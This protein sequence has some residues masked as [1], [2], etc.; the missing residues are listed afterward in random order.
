MDP[1]HDLWRRHPRAVASTLGVKTGFRSAEAD[2]YHALAADQSRI[3]TVD[4]RTEALVIGCIWRTMFRSAMPTFVV[5]NTP[6]Q[7]KWLFEVAEKMIG[8][9]GDVRGL[10]WV[11]YGHQ[12][13]SLAS[14]SSLAVV[15]M[16]PNELTEK[17][18]PK[19]SLV[20]VPN[21]DAVETSLIRDLGEKEEAGKISLHVNV[22]RSRLLTT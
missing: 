16:L 13:L 4:L 1:L 15:Y 11:G 19:R 20:V 17:P 22:S 5:V 2:Y 21:L 18:L 12:G 9:S 7:G 6:L 8:K 10:V 3:G 14:S